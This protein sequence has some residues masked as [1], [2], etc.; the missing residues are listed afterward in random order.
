MRET[1]NQTESTQSF[2]TEQVNRLAHKYSNAAWDKVL[3]KE[4]ERF[5]SPRLRNVG[6]LRL[7]A[8]VSDYIDTEPF[9][10][11]EKFDGHVPTGNTS[12]STC[13]RCANG[14]PGPGYVMG[15]SIRHIEDGGDGKEY[16]CAQRCRHA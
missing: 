3:R 14:Y 11:Q 6:E 16:E 4:W 5:L 9:L 13:P 7:Y 2:V 15:T 12:V 1:R 8:A 10:A